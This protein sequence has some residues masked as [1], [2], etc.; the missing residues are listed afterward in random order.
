MAARPAFQRFAQKNV[1]R[2]ASSPWYKRMKPIVCFLLIAATQAAG[3]GCARTDG[4]DRTL[5]TVDVSGNWEL[6]EGFSPI[7]T[8][9]LK[10]QGSTVTGFI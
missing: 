9:D 8:F 7:T 4:I 3:S 1:E 5:V 2:S 6:V 10:Q